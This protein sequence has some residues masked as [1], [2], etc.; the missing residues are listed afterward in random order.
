[1]SL[2]IIVVSAKNLPN[3]ELVGKV[4]P[5]VTINYQGQFK[6]TEVIKNELN[7]V[8]NASLEW[9]LANK[10]LGPTDVLEIDVRDWELVGR[11]RLLGNATVSLRDVLQSRRH[12]THHTVNLADGT[13]RQTTGELTIEI[14]YVPPRSAAGGDQQQSLDPVPGT[15]VFTTI[16]DPA[17]DFE[18][19]TDMSS[20]PMQA[21]DIKER[22]AQRKMPKLNRDKLSQK[23][24]D[25]QLRV[26]VWEA[27]QLSGSNINPVSKV[28][29]V[30]SAQTTRVKHA[31]SKPYFDEVFFFN[32]HLAPTELMDEVLLC[33]VFDSRVLRSDALIGSFS[34]D[35]G[36]I[37]GSE[38]H[39]IQNK[40]LMLTEEDVNKSGV[41]G[42][43]Q[44]S[45]SL[46]GPGDEAPIFIKG[47]ED[48]DIE[49]N[50]LQPPGMAVQKG[51][52]RFKVF[53]AE[54]LPQMD[55]SVMEGMKKVL[56]VGEVQ[57]ELVDPYLIVSYAGKSM[58]TDIKYKNDHPDWNQEIN[59]PISFPSMCERIKLQLRDWDRLSSDDFIGTAFLELN[60]ISSRGDAGF[61]PTFGPCFVNFYGSTREFDDVRD[62]YEW[63]NTG[64]GKGMAY[65][66]RVLLSVDT[67]IGSPA[68][69]NPV[70][71]M[72]H[73]ELAR[74]E[75][76]LRRRKYRLY[77]SFH[78]AC[79]INETETQASIEFEVSIGNFGNKLEKNV[80]PQPSSTQPSNAVY[81]GLH[82]YFLPWLANKPLIVVDSYWE[83]ISFRSESL[84][85]LFTKIKKTEKLLKLVKTSLQSGAPATEVAAKLIATIDNLIK[86]CKKP[87]PSLV[88]QSGK[89]NELDH[90]RYEQ[91]SNTLREIIDAATKLRE[92]ATDIEEAIDEIDGYLT[93]LKELAVEPQNSLPDIVL[94]MLSGGKRVA[95]RRIPVYEVIY[96][97]KGK[98]ACGRYCGIVKTFFLKYPGNRG[99]SIGAERIPGTVRVGLWFGLELESD[100]FRKSLKDSHMAIFAETYENQMN[101]VGQWT[102]KGLPRPKFSDASGKIALPK[103][104][105]NCPDLWSWDG[106]WFVS[107]ETSL[108]YD[109]D[110]GM[111]NFLED[112]YEMQSRALPGAP[113]EVAA[114]T[115]ATVRGDSLPKKEDIKC[116]KNWQWD[117]EWV[118]DINRGVDEEGYEYSYEATTAKWTATE[119]PYHLC[120]RRRW[121][122]PRSVV[123]K[124]R[125]ESEVTPEVETE[126][127]EYATTFFNSRY[128]ASESKTD[129]VRRR[130]W[131]RRMVARSPRASVNFSLLQSTPSES[132]S[133]SSPR[134]YLLHDKAYKYQMRAYMYQARDLMASDSD[135]FS[136]PYAYVSFLHRSGKT[137]IIQHSLCPIWD[138]T[139][140]FEEME[141]HG[142]PALFAASP[143]D[144]IVEIF[145]S[146]KF[147]NDELLG[148]CQIQPMI[149]TDTRDQRV[150]RLAWHTV[151]RS[152]QT[153]GEL[154]ASFEL[155]LI[156]DNTD[157]PFAPPM[158]GNL[159]MVPKG[160]RPVLQ[161]TGVEILCWGVRNMKKYMQ[162]SV[163]SPMI[164]FEI[165]GKMVESTMISNVTNNPNFSDPVLFLEVDL[166]REELYTPPINIKIRDNRAFGRKP[167]V[168]VA[169]VKHLAGYRCTV[170]AE[171]AKYKTSPPSSP[172]I[173][174]PTGQP[175]IKKR[176]SAVTFST[177]EGGEK[178]EEGGGDTIVTMPEDVTDGPPEE[179]KKTRKKTRFS[180]AMLKNKQSDQVQSGTSLS[181]RAALMETLVDDEI[182]WWSKYY[183]S[184]GDRTKSHCYM[185]K[186]YDLMKMYRTELEEVE[187]F[188]EF[189]DFCET[190]H[191]ARGKKKDVSSSESVGEFKGLFKIY[192]LPSGTP[193]PPPQFHHLPSSEMVQCLVRVYIIRAIDLA[194]KDKNGLSDPYLKVSLGDTNLDDCENYKPNTLNPFF[195]RVFELKTSLPSKKDLTITVM[196]KDLL[197][198]DDLIGSTT[199]DLENRYLT[200]HRATCGLPATY[201]L[202]GIN[203]W[204][205]ALT[206]KM[207]LDA[208]CEANNITNP[209]YNEDACTMIFNG[210][211]HDLIMY[212]KDLIHHEHLGPPDQRLALHILNNLNFVSEHVETRRLF[213]PLMPGI[214][215]G[216]IEMWVDIFPLHLGSPGP[217]VDIS[218]R[219]PKK[220]ELRCVIWNTKD[221]ILD[222]MSITGERMSDIYVKGWLA[223]L[224]EK[225]E[226]DVHYRSLNGTGNFNW[227][228]VFE[229]DYIP[230]E[231]VM[232]IT[233]KEH[234]WSLDKTEIRVPPTLIIQIWDNDKFSPDDFLGT[235]E[236]NLNNMP[237][238]V[239]K[240]KKCSL[241]QLPDPVGQREVPM[242]SLFEQKRV[243]GW[244]PC[245]NEETGERELTGKVEMELEI[246]DEEEAREKPTAPA[247][248]DPNQYPTLEPPIRPETSFQWISSP[249][250]SLRY[251]IWFNFK[252]YI[253]YGLL[254]AFL[255]FFIVLFVYNVPGVTVQKVFGV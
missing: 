103:D 26:K 11:N 157:L 5:I 190:F 231:Q 251:I 175:E 16:P 50:L 10:P 66:G 183:A 27:R 232:V 202:T 43:L 143:P 140:I 114:V 179:K 149:K 148:R 237:A 218:P 214:D 102:S 100:N 160:I 208:Y 69:E 187:G 19:E 212:E 235:L 174:V 161:R 244:W 134:L 35:L 167:I 8:W 155:F 158:R 147:N 229:F 74:A 1:M 171:E 105:F 109:V 239:K 63:M 254:I 236:L 73:E 34:L 132:T 118:V 116:P 15:P 126:G 238:S 46:I 178:T 180:V 234:I 89:A 228:F 127:W 80:T 13:G 112:C 129:M 85:N 61:L 125:K 98:E 240:A 40:W 123:N 130:R 250:M 135:S 12:N 173:I 38:E 204:R 221:V 133:M 166:P 107:L 223:G 92:N 198:R 79:M 162:L 177:E 192:P 31:T 170:A 99:K 17:G 75:K 150:P 59:L 163:L 152:G 21:S 56:H 225:Q 197:S 54:D 68:P 176:R 233:Q 209:V 207:V 71:P 115:Y 245:M 253:I 32:F 106:D 82:Y 41:K 156:E 36:V 139:I 33:Q 91:R 151:Y 247:R 146:D 65:R 168:G 210:V 215:Q 90:R 185:E 86:D 22:I 37:Y 131:H 241:K 30:G 153:A 121:I 45:A 201:C 144:V 93:M 246:L 83:D 164:E 255:V 142:D 88:G 216:R 70:L 248:D 60:D 7:P 169:V 184:I 51:V 29:C 25:F 101:I 14:K 186:G 84:N 195:G 4:D 181:E 230:P 122:R 64:K 53:H 124:S 62:Q 55:S 119:K 67:M 217:M 159:Y 141:I 154:L 193:V 97:S 199:I 42:Y 203:R 76:Y 138:Q 52:F 191:L 220:F 6:S 211:H 165:G 28:T 81:D 249:W 110:A 18:G 23:T 219:V 194:P 145:D 222:E 205:D 213:T 49:A 104:K 78:E 128:Q 9:D 200:A 24:Q 111:T 188:H 242:V 182:D 47:E 117:D 87:L 227:R 3:L 77:A 108:L 48:S 44:I 113:W 20:Q 95:Y 2:T 136:D 120:R 226:T 189:E 172:A 39:A 94:W 96:S 206:P 224:D 252:Y 72:N 196:D 243:R 57:K 58:M 137:E